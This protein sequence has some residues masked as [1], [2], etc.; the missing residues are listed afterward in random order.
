MYHYT[1][2]EQSKKLVELGLNP[3][4]A[5]MYYFCDPTPAGNV[6]HP[7]LIIVEKYLHSRLPEYDKGDIPCWS[8]GAL[9]EL[10]PKAQED[11][12]NGEVY[13]IV[14]KSLK[15]D[16]WNCVNRSTLHITK[17]YASPIDA[18][19]EMI[20]WLLENNCMKKEKTKM[21]PKIMKYCTGS[22]HFEESGKDSE[23]TICSIRS[24]CM[25]YLAQCNLKNNAE[26]KKEYLYI[27]AADCMERDNI[28]QLTAENKQKH[29]PNL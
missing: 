26:S 25:R 5:D 28:L 2:I 3:D 8:L 27:N 14:C 15:N 4:T 17:S 16:T 24:R 13:P 29:T 11:G 12:N 10:M 9:L 20:C 7:T 6:M 18:A 19:F 21:N 22:A 23:P 1:T